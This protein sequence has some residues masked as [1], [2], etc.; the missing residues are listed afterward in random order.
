MRIANPRILAVTVS[1]L[2]WFMYDQASAQAGRGH[3]SP[4]NVL[5]LF[6]DQHAAAV[7][8]SAGSDTVLTP[9]LDRLADEGV[10]FT[11]CAVS[12]PLCTPSRA[13]I[14]TG[15]YAELH[16]ANDNNVFMD[17]PDTEYIAEIFADAGYATG[18]A[19][20]WHLDGAR[21][22]DGNLTRAQRV[23]NNSYVPADRRRGYQE[24]YGYEKGLDHDTPAYWD[25]SVDPPELNSALSYDWELSFHRDV[26]LDFTQVH[27]DTGTPWMYFLSIGMPH[28]P[29]EAPTEFVDLYPLEDI[30]IPDWITRTLTDDEMDTALAALQI[31][32][33]QISFVDDEIGLI[34]DA[35]ED[36]GQ[37]DNTII[38]YTSDHG[39]L[40]GSHWGEAWSGFNDVPFN[41]REKNTPFEN[42]IRVPL[43]V[44]WPELIPAGLVADPLISSVDLPPTIL[45]LAGLSIPAKMQGLNMEAWCLGEL[46]PER[47]AVYLSR[48]SD[49]SPDWTALW[50]WDY[51][52]SPGSAYPVLYEYQSDPYETTNLFDTAEVS[53]IQ[54]DL[55]ARL[56]E[57]EDAALD[58]GNAAQLPRETEAGATSVE[59]LVPCFIASAAYGSPLASELDGLR[60]VRDARLLTNPAG[61]A[62]VDTYYRLS[63]AIADKVSRS[64]A[65]GAAVRAVLKPVI[66]ASRFFMQTRE[67]PAAVTSPQPE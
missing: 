11:R 3:S 64:P 25:D 32:Y 46:G 22:Q 43:I 23:G 38:I 51:L 16:G 60:D 37:A 41:F 18:Y 4:P 48:Q 24:W 17:S 57:L 1:I 44:R 65:L 34:L 50:T 66:S 6:S 14:Q 33:A 35:L 63:P 9:N 2:I 10:R 15:L 53:D 5:I 7:L 12:H 29:E 26:L 28:T 56:T 40:L 21:D 36:Q 59:G 62:F 45:G 55:N 8:G 67:E 58:E 47:D 27:G 61:S 19:G 49:D 20:K 39:D 54:A 52:Y 31:Y 30:Q 42:A 13:T